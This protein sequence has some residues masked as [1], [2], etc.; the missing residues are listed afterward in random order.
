VISRLAAESPSPSGAARLSDQA[1]CTLAK[2]VLLLVEVVLLM[3]ELMAVLFSRTE[4]WC[5]YKN[6]PRFELSL[7]SPDWPALGAVYK[8]RE[9]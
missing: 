1:K 9:R 3:K 6:P 4:T 7:S 5:D 2:D 8:Q